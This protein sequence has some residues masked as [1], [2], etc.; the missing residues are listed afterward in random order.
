MLPRNGIAA[1]V[2]FLAIDFVPVAAQEHGVLAVPAE[3]VTSIALLA[4]MRDRL[5]KP[6]ASCSIRVTRNIASPRETPSRCMIK[7]S[8]RSRSAGASDPLVRRRSIS[9]FISEVS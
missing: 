3:A 2:A 8:S 5:I 6:L 7:A 9:R 4:E 1:I